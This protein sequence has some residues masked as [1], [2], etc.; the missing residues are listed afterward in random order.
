MLS[1]DSPEK[2]V[3][4]GEITE[5]IIKLFRNRESSTC[6]H[7]ERQYD[8]SVCDKCLAQRMLIAT[9]KALDAKD[10]AYKEQ[11]EA[12]RKLDDG[13]MKEI[14]EHQAQI[15][16]LEEA[17]EFYAD[18][19]NWDSSTGACRT[20]HRQPNTV[21]GPGETIEEADFGYRAE[22]ALTKSKARRKE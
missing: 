22:Q 17:L 4:N 14:S 19:K 11:L 1:K 5:S 20:L 6:D 18:D 9:K 8:D 16:E 10:A 13:R 7:C 12:T 3:G 2:V 15:K 21:D